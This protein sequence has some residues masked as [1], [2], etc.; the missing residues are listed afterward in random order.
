[1]KIMWM[2]GSYDSTWKVANARVGRRKIDWT[3]E[4]PRASIIMYGFPLQ[5]SLR[6]PPRIIKELKEQYKEICDECIYIYY[7]I[8]IYY[9]YYY[10]CEEGTLGNRCMDLARLALT[11]ING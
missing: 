7:I 1:M 4:V 10:V 3:D 6:L 9:V 5:P 11:K 8:Y 2:D